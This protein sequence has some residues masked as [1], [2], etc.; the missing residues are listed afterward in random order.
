M[1][2][3]FVKLTLVKSRKAIMFKFNIKNFANTKD[4]IFVNK[5]L[6]VYIL[7]ILLLLI[8]IINLILF[9]TINSITIAYFIRLLILYF[10]ICLLS[11]NL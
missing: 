10:S 8:F 11:Q 2:S 5:I 1:F 3:K 9:R 4:F 6:Q 7:L